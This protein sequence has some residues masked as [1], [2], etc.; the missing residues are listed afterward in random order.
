MSIVN[1]KIQ[2]LNIDI[3]NQ[4]IKEAMKNRGLSQEEVAGKIN[5]SQPNFS[6]AINNRD[7]KCF[8]LNQMFMLSQYFG[9]SI[10]ELTGNT[11][12]RTDKKEIASMIAKLITDE[13][14]KFY[15]ISIDETVYLP[16][17]MVQNDIS[18]ETMNTKYQ[19]LYFPNYW[20]PSEKPDEYGEPNESYYDAIY[21][22]NDTDNAS[23]NTFLDKLKTISD[24]YFSESI[25]KEDIDTLIK[26]Y[27][28]KI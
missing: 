2:E 9:L 19:A 21:N 20:Q 18:T 23:L 27:I 28:E 6:K 15:P 5:M 25:D 8:T 12:V 14:A 26:K 16:L 4:K 17:S 3:L 13:T 1:N 22:G 11:A 10:D 7:G 24:A